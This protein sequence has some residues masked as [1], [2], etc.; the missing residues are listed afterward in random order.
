MESELSPY[1]ILGDGTDYVTLDGG[2]KKH[3]VSYFESFLFHRDDIHRLLKTFS[4]GEKSRLQLALNLTR[5]GDILI[6]DE[7][8]NDLDLETIQILEKKLAEFDGAVIIIS[9]D[10]TFLSNVTNKIFL[11]ENQ[12]ITSFEVGFD[13]VEPYLEALE[14]EKMAESEKD[15]SESPPVQV[16]KTKPLKSEKQKFTIETLYSEIEKNEEK[17]KIIEEKIANFDFLKLKDKDNGELK[18]LNDAQ[19]FLQEKISKLYQELEIIENQ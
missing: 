8:T 17:L 19:S 11:V 16:P 14:L 2:Q 10:R 7:P 18:I 13:Q 4:G 6:F 5:P 3:V 1:K 12:N 9:H 15:L